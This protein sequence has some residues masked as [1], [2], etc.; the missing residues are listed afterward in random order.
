MSQCKVTAL[1]QFST[2]A[3]CSPN[4]WMIVACTCMTLLTMI[5]MMYMQHGF[6]R[7]MRWL[8]FAQWK[9]QQLA[10]RLRYQEPNVTLLEQITRK[11]NEKKNT[12]KNAFDFFNNHRDANN[13]V[14]GMSDQNKMT[15]SGKGNGAT[16]LV[17]A[18]VKKA[19]DEDAEKVLRAQNI[20]ANTPLIPKA[21]KSNDGSQKIL[22]KW[23]DAT[24]DILAIDDNDK[25]DEKG[26]P[27]VD[28]TQDD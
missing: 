12:D 10:E 19:K 16:D 5:L 23:T 8:Q 13:N 11:V 6:R 4:L 22:K 21:Q 2:Y 24:K 1:D 3:L 9:L 14:A 17:A 25:D 27:R 28:R 20:D 26:N 7:D 15:T 18:Q